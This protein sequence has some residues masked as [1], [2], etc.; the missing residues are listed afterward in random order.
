MCFVCVGVMGFMDKRGKMDLSVG[1]IV[2]I[3]VSILLAAVV[4]GALIT[5][6]ISYLSNLSTLPVVGSFFA[7]GGIMGML[8]GIAVFLGFLGLLGFAGAS[9]F[10]GG[11]RRR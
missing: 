5:V 4:G 8:I 9:Y 2:S 11:K 3:S 6:A 7:S 1:G 10:G